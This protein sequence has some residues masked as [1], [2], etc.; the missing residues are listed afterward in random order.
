MTNGNYHRSFRDAAAWEMS[1][2]RRSRFKIGWHRRLGRTLRR[3][4]GFLVVIWSYLELFGWKKTGARLRSTG[5]DGRE[6]AFPRF[7]V[8][9]WR[10]A[11]I[12]WRCCGQD[13]HTPV[14]AVVCSF[15]RR[16]FQRRRAEGA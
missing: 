8:W 16:I 14:L 5:R 4:L 6:A 7:S 3:A 11:R 2:V 15:L 1:R 12:I 10:S 13:G 9:L